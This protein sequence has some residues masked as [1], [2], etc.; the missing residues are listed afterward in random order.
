M[1]LRGEMVK[2]RKGEKEKEKKRKGKGE[3]IRKSETEALL[4]PLTGK[5]REGRESL[6]FMCVMLF[7]SLNV[8]F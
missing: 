5:A 3:K 2:G 6:I 4:R 1:H 8:M 7:C